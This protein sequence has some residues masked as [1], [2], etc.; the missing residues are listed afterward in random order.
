LLLKGLSVGNFLSKKINQQLSYSL[1]IIVGLLGLIVSINWIYPFPSSIDETIHTSVPMLFQTGIAFAISGLT[2]ILLH[3]GQKLVVLVL[4]YILGLFAALTLLEY[5][6]D[7]QFFISQYITHKMESPT[8]P[9]GRV[10]PNTAFCFL[11]VSLTLISEVSF[12]P[13][14][15]KSVICLLFALL[16]MF[17]SSITLLGFIFHWNTGWSSFTLMARH[18][19]LG[20][21]AWSLSFMI[22]KN[23]DKRQN[24]VN[25]LLPMIVIFTISALGFIIL[26]Q[27]QAI[28]E[29]KQIAFIVSEN[30]QQ[31]IQKLTTNFDRTIQALNRFATSWEEAEIVDEQEWLREAS[32]Y[33]NDFPF[34]TLFALINH[35]NQIQWDV[36]QGKSQT[37]DN[38]SLFKQSYGIF[39]Y[40]SR[41]T[42]T[43]IPQEL[44]NKH[45]V[46]P[47]LIPLVDKQNKINN[48]LLSAINMHVFINFILDMQTKNQ[49]FIELYNDNGTLYSNKRKTLL[50]QNELLNQTQEIQLLN[51][52][53]T[54]QLSPSQELLNLYY[55][56]LPVITL[57]AGLF[58]SALFAFLTYMWLELR[59]S[60]RMAQLILESA[61]EGIY[62]LDLTGGVSF[63]NAAAANMLLWNPEDILHLKAHDLI[64]YKRHN[65]NNYPI[66][67]C[68]IYNTLHDGQVH[69]RDDEVYWRKDGSYF[70]V[71][72]DSNPIKLKGKTIGAVITFRD[73]TK[74]IENEQ[75]LH[76]QKNYLVAANKELEGFSYT[77]SHDLRAPLRHII[78]YMKYLTLKVTPLKDKEIDEYIDIVTSESIRM[79]NLIDDLLSFARAGRLALNK[80]ITNSKEIVETIIARSNKELSNRKI[81][82]EV[83]NLPQVY[84][85]PSM[86]GI[87]W[88]NLI[89][90]AVK[91][92]KFKKTSKIYISYEETQEDYCFTIKDNGV[93]FD[94]EYSDKLFGVFKRLHSQE[95]FEGTGI[96]L[97][98]VHRIVTR[99]GGRVWAQSKLGQGSEFNFS[100]PKRRS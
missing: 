98:N 96:G 28:Q 97:S 6:L 66:I 23:K 68:P 81:I 56:I 59:E 69:H 86:L 36:P 88:E 45:K 52:S 33:L 60:Q 76:R 26:W 55:T 77:V 1:A 65:G 95:E 43:G 75:E 64:H 87:V 18:S 12:K 46:L 34:L 44:S 71:E 17:L 29:T 94:M 41:N 16:I 5:F 37:F 39:K 57:M 50:Y 99:H 58:L 84:A 24:S 19:A 90:N 78:G 93:G 62:G 54:L 48:I 92:T 80:K 61:G 11:L 14:H 74:R 21:I 47:I 32:A 3:H 49:Y 70:N 38:N 25:N 7:I 63:I 27:V 8:S 91:F 100:L 15:E 79:G 13:G 82:W 22:C 31:I 72:Y 67:E 2:L 40:Q 83:A 73:I 51:Q 42:S 85:D 9:T 20:F 10:A 30:K 35:S 89:S 53:W 4:A